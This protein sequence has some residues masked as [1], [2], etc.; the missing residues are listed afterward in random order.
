MHSIDFF[1]QS[2]QNFI[3]QKEANKTNFG[4]FCFLIYM[5]IMLI[6]CIL[7]LLDYIFNDKY[8]I[9]YSLIKNLSP[10][11]ESRTKEI[12]ILN[13]NKQLNPNISVAFELYNLNGKTLS[14]N[15]VILDINDG[16]K[17]IKRRTFIEKKVTDLSL[18]IYYICN[19]S[20]LENCE[21]EKED[22]SLL[23]YRIRMIYTGF[24]LKHNETV[25]IQKDNETYF[26][27]NY[28]FFFNYILIRKLYWEV[29]K[30]KEEKGISRLWD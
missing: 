7:Y 1:S 22:D 28:E 21:R 23:N 15:F 25:P 26:E 4:G 10:I 29:I 16:Y 8:E 14:Q 19:T 17:E 12:N 24:N 5:I 11:T 18:G 20:D 6:I 27:E 3:F 9:E 30:Y 13:E 2:P